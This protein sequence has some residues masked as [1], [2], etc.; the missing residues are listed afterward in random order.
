MTTI[1]IIGAGAMGSGVGRR[2]HEN[3]ARVLALLDGRSNASRE[4]AAVAGMEDASLAA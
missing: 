3:G 2:L 4:R 1:A